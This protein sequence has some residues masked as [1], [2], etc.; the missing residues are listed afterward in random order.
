MRRWAHQQLRQEKTGKNGGKRPPTVQWLNHDSS[1]EKHPVRTTLSVLDRARKIVKDAYFGGRRQSVLLSGPP[2]PTRQKGIRPALLQ[3]KLAP[4]KTHGIVNKRD[5]YLPLCALFAVFCQD[6]LAAEFGGYAALTTDYVRR[7]VTQS[8]GSPALQL[9]TEVSFENGFYVGMWGSTIDISNGPTRQRDL[10]VD[11]YAGYSLDTSDAW[12]VSAGIVSYNYPGQTGNIDYDYV[13]YLLGGSF[14]DRVWLD[15]AYSPDL[16]NSGRSTTN[17]E[18][19]AEW[20]IG[21]TWAI[22]GGAGRYD[23]SALTGSTYL[24]WQLGVT[25]SLKWA[26]IDLRAFD[27]DGSVPIVST[28][29]RARSRLVLTVRVPF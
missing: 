19:Y 21:D 15:F 2:E 17:I 26:D 22:A 23:T 9:A 16:Y 5:F 6:A 20:P 7:G 27:T 11:Y 24:Y 25:A 8:D 18:L 3:G 28:P 10:E 14:R 29:E 1:P 13:E 4:M 12:R